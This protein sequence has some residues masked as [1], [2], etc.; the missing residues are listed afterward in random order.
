MTLSITKVMGRENILSAFK[1]MDPQKSTEYPL[2][3]SAV[4]S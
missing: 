1:G 4:K 2:R 3:I